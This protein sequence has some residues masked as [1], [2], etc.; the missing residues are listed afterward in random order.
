MDA[1]WSACLHAVNFVRRLGPQQS[2]MYLEQGQLLGL[3][4]A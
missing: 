1:L 2:M 4:T 3:H